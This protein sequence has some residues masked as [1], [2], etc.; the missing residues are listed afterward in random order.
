MSYGDVGLKFQ[1]LKTLFRFS[2]VLWSALVS[3]RTGSRFFSEWGSCGS[4][5]LIKHTY[6]PGRYK[7]LFERLEIRLLC[8]FWSIFMLVDPNPHSQYG[9]GSGPILIRIHN[10]GLKRIVQFPWPVR[11]KDF[12]FV[13]K[14]F[15]LFHCFCARLKSSFLLNLILF[16]LETP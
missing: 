6:V 9:S 1:F 11:K 15:M 12:F 16:S 14:R 4:G 5:M 7:S 13:R 2:A 10:T 8:L 3:M